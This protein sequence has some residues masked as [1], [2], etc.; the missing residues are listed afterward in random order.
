MTIAQGLTGST[1]RETIRHES[2]HA[3]LTP[4]IG[5]FLTQ[6]T[7]LNIWSYTIRIY[8]ASLKKRLPNHM[9]LAACGWE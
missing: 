2:I 6:R 3:F 5:P 8:A 4:R 1:L 7:A 9:L